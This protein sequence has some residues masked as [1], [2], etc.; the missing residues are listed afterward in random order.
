M[1]ENGRNEFMV[2]L[3]EPS[4]SVEYVGDTTTILSDGTM[5]QLPVQD[6]ADTIRENPDKY[7]PG[8]TIAH[9]K[10]FVGRFIDRTATGQ[11]DWGD[12]SPRDV[13]ADE[14]MYDEESGQYLLPED[15]GG[16]E[17]TGDTGAADDLFEPA[18]PAPQPPYEYP[19]GSWA[20]N[21]AKAVRAAMRPRAPLG[22]EGEWAWETDTS[23]YPSNVDPEALQAEAELGQAWRQ[24]KQKRD[25]AAKR[26]LYG[27]EGTSKGEATGLQ[28]D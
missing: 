4:G 8:W 23:T 18:P 17:D 20:A 15:T 11:N 28:E 19:K 13:I 2:P 22:S 10:A 25:R 7:P 6:L 1:A 14:I 9:E 26:A 16:M 21:R 5:Y 24:A 12:R 27:A 3:H